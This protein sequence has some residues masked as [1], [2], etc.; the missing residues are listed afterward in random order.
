[1]T[2]ALLF[3]LRRCIVQIQSVQVDSACTRR[4]FNL[5]TGAIIK[6]RNMGLCV[7]CAIF[8]LKIKKV[9]FLA[10]WPRGLQNWREPKIS[11]RCYWRYLLSWPVLSQQ[12][13]MRIYCWLCNNS[14]IHSWLWKA[15]GLV[16]CSQS[17]SHITRARKDETNRKKLAF[18]LP[19]RMSLLP[20]EQLL[21]IVPFQSTKYTEKELCVDKKIQETIGDVYCPTFRN[22]KCV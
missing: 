17:S 13:E 8:L 3:S 5:L 6:V 21:L 14:E 10:A 9:P 22:E 12:R 11:S 19:K 15:W 18:S 20:E 1:M 7:R 4:L 16:V 2:I